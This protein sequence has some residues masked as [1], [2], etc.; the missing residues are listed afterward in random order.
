MIL[1]F[2]NI[3]NICLCIFVLELWVLW[4]QHCYENSFY[5]IWNS[6]RFWLR[7]SCGLICY[8]SFGQKSV[9]TAINDKGE[10]TKQIFIGR[11]HYD[12]E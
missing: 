11:N 12:D 4:W 7:V 9:I 10:I 2:E 6:C 1:A 5:A 8:L 3:A